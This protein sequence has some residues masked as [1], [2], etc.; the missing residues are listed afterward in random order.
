MLRVDVTVNVFQAGLVHVLMSVLGPVAVGVGVRVLHVV[1]LVRG[2]C[3]GMNHVAVPVFM[4]MWC[5]V[6]VLFGHQCRLPC[7]NTWCLL[8]VSAGAAVL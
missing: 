5:V 3:M 7:A 6:G 1:M 8:V 2:M 4:C